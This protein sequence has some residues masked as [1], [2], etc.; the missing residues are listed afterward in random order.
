MRVLTAL[1][2]AG[3]IAPGAPA[4]AATLDPL[5]G[6]WSG[7]GTTSKLPSTQVLEF[8]PTLDGRFVELSLRNEMTRPDGAAIV[9][10]GRGFYRTG[11]EDGA[12]PGFWMD[13]LGEM[14]RIEATFDGA[15]LVAVW[16][17]G[18]KQGRSTYEL[19]D[20]RLHV[21]DEI[22]KADGEWAVFGRSTLEGV[23]AP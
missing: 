21:T 1:V 8:A 14:H 7:T 9:F 12:I 20:D 13:S 18:E 3:A 23:P 5:L 17:S 4:G 22:R 6:R 10:Q 16:S 2:V 11:T 19:A 15:R